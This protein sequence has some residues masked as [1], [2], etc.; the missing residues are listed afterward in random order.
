ML[1]YSFAMSAAVGAIGGILITPTQY[2][3]FHIAT[4]YSVNGFVAAL[5]GGLGNIQPVHSSAA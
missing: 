4:P 3:A 1:V 5:I 2:R